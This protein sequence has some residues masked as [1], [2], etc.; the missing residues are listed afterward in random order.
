MFGFSFFILFLVHILFYNSVA[1]FLQLFSLD[2]IFP[3]KL[4]VM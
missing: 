1:Y 2:E 3:R 4:S